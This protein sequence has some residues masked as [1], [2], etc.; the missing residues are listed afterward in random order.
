MKNYTECSVINRNII[1][2]YFIY[3]FIL[4]VNSLKCKTSQ[5]YIKCHLQCCHQ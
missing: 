1:D 2:N 5:S 4:I 3:L